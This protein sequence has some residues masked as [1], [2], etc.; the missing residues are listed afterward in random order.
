MDDSFDTLIASAILAPSGDNTQPWRFVVDRRASQISIFV[1]ESRDRSA[2]NAGQRMSRIACGA[3]AEN[4]IQSSRSQLW[5]VRL[6]PAISGALLTLHL[7]KGELSPAASTPQTEAIAARITNRRKYNGTPLPA[8]VLEELRQAAPK[9]EGVTTHWICDR[10]RL[11]ALALLVGQSDALMFGDP[12]IRKAFFSNVRFDAAADARV[13]DGLSMAS[14]ELSFVDRVA[15]RMVSRSPD[16]IVRLLG[17]TRSFNSHARKLI[18]SSSGLC[19]IATATKSN[20]MDVSAGRALQRAWLALTVKSMAAQPMMSLLVLSNILDHGSP[21]IIAAIGAE[22]INSLL[23]KF[24]AL[25]PEIGSDFTA[26][27]L[28]FGYAAAPSGQTGRLPVSA[29]RENKL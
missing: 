16:W 21:E 11:T 2:M 29:V 14:L 1:N 22:K 24:R 19:L 27:I 15:L 7:E 13:A 9:I 23:E 12:S 28:R 17:L 6:A 10:G 4:L 8:P 20:E 5:N 3:A 25:V 26:F 18:E